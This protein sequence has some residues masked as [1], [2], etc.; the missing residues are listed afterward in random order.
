M[1]NFQ[2]IEFHLGSKEELLPDFTPDFPY[3]TSHFRFDN[4][5]GH[6]VPWHW[7]K[8]VELFYIESGELVYSTPKGNIVF[9]E[10]AGGMV[11]SN[12]LHMTKPQAGLK[13]AVQLLHIFDPSLVAGQQGSR[14]EQQYILPITSA[15][16]I[17]ILPLFPTVQEHIPLLNKIQDSFALS[18]QAFGYEL[19]LRSTLSEIWLQFLAFAGPLPEENSSADSSNDKVKSM[20]VYIHEHYAEK[21]S[22]ADIASAAFCS[23]RECYRVFS[24]YLRTTPAVYTN[25]YRLQKACFLLANSQHPIT[26]ICHTCGLGS[27][28]YFGKVFRKQMGCTPL[29]YREKWQNS[30]IE[31]Q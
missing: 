24:A 17:E 23:E 28:S 7:H 16:Q 27:S 30:D 5:M 4:T 12:V 21:L 14:I 18:P 13:S 6:F 31:R 3:I 8:A 19:A 20:I 2:H 1:I 26:S 29:E 10:G 15:P 11:N 22:V 9:S 25:N